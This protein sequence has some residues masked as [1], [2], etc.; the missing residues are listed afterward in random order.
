VNGRKV[1]LSEPAAAI[2]G[3]IALVP[4]ER[5]KQGVLVSE[6]VA[7]NLSLPI[8]G[9]ISR[10]GVLSRSL[11]RR[12]ADSLVARLGIK[13]TSAGQLVNYLSGGNQ[14][15]VS[16]GK[17]LE[18]SASVFVFDEPTK[19]V[20]IGAKSDIFRIIGMLAEQ[21]KAIVYM[22]CEFSEALGIADRIFVMYD[23]RL[24]KSFG[25]GEA[26]QEKLLL[27]ASGGEES[28]T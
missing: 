28:S 7:R 13:T 4:E 26:T 23:G 25:R 5:R 27:Y 20:D 3:G 10:L 1:E 8:L 2:E 18:T 22:T 12:N 17:W 9:R 19:G 11:E 24:V 21:G 15:K 6:S 16:I 14:Q